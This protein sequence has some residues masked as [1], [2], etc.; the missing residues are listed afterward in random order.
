MDTIQTSL[1]A[2]R[3]AVYAAFIA[4]LT[5]SVAA[6][7][8]IGVRMPTLRR[9][10]ADIAKTDAALPFLDAAPHA[11]YEENMLHVLLIDLL[12]RGYGDALMRTEAFL[13][14]LDNWAVCDAF[15]PRAFGKDHADLKTR[16]SAWLKSERVYTVRFGAVIL[17]RH[18]LEKD[19]APELLLQA[20]RLDTEEYYINMALAWLLCEALIKQYA[21][22][23]PYLESGTLNKWVHNKAIQKSVESYRLSEETKAYLRTLRR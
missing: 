12:C 8:V 10:A 15:R 17:M 1:F 13:P 23:L 3:D 5:P 14:H 18:F 20:L 4:R 21:S 11:Y 16:V 9:M 22:A 19:F 7:T 6:D 2:A